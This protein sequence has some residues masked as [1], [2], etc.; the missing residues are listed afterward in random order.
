MEDSDKD[1]R[2][3][4]ENMKASPADPLIPVKLGNEIIVC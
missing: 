1:W 4:G 2:R 3:P